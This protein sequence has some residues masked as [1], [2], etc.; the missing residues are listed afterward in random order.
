MES[1]NAAFE[2]SDVQNSAESDISSD[3]SEIQI[4]PLVDY[5]D[6]FRQTEAYDGQY[7]SVAGRITNFNNDYSFYFNE[8]LGLDDDGLGFRISLDHTRAIRELYSIGDYVVV[9]GV[10]HNGYFSELQ[11]A[12]IILDGTAAYD[13]ASE[14]GQGKRSVRPRN[15]DC[16]LHANCRKH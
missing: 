1:Q 15:T 9:E 13:T 7:I 10:W 6:V 8:R 3:D 14:M 12:R 4:P 2:A 11:K 16:Q 5:V